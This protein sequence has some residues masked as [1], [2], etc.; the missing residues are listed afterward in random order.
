MQEI[1]HR[2][3]N[4]GQDFSQLGL[5]YGIGKE[6]YRGRYFDSQP[7]TA[8]PTILF[9]KIRTMTEGQLLKPFPLSK[10]IYALLRLEKFDQAILNE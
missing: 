3:N 10:K 1:Y 2:I 8:L 9:P 7:L 4:D 5:Q 6:K